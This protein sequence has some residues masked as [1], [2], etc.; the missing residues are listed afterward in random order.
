MAQFDEPKGQISILVGL[1]IVALGLL[2]LLNTWG[3]VSFTLPKIVLDVLPTIALF[4]IPALAIFLFIDAIDEDDTIKGLTIILGLVFLALGVIQLL[5]RFGVIGW[6]L[7]ISDM[8]YQIIF[9]IEGL[10]LV[11]ATFAM[12]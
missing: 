6:A 9:A 1:V 11:I 8:V 2:P 3:M 12:D 7:P 5:N 4:T 10:F